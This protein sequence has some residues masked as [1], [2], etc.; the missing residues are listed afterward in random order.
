MAVIGMVLITVRIN[1]IFPV[2]RLPAYGAF[3]KHVILIARRMILFPLAGNI[4][5]SNYFAAVVANEAFFYGITV[6]VKEPAVFFG[7]GACNY[8][9]APDTYKVPGM[10]IFPVGF[11]ISARDLF[12]AVVAFLSLSFK[13]RKKYN[14]KE[15][16]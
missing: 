10:E 13:R 5:P 3:G 14:Q 1:C 12:T 11:N 6:G 15:T 9:S 16:A 8:F 4:L 2:K 7:K